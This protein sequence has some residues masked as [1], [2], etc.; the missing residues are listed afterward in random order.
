MAHQ[1]NLQLCKAVENFVQF[2]ASLCLFCSFLLSLS[3]VPYLVSSTENAVFLSLKN[4]I[5]GKKGCS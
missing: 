5:D 4:T 2:F 3:K 1:Q